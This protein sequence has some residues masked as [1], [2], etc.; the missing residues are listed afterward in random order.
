MYQITAPADLRMAT[1]PPFK[2]LP[3]IIRV[4]LLKRQDEQERYPMFTRQASYE[5]E[6]KTYDEPE[7]EQYRVAC[8]WCEEEQGVH[9]FGSHG[10]CPE[11]AEAMMEEHRARIA[12][13]AA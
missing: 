10:I 1:N 12:R 13:R 11:H 9:S 8:A 3:S 4:S 5:P 7:E 6:V 2:R